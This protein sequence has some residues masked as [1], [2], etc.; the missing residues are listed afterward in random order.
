L[1]SHVTRIARIVLASDGILH[2]ADHHNRLELGERI[3]EGRVGLRQEQHVALVNR[4]PATNARAVEPE[5]I[6]EQVL[7]ELGNGDAEMLPYARKIHKAEIRALDIILPAHCQD[8][9]RRHT[10]GSFAYTL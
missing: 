9:L 1:A 3:D 2:V 7:G 10:E 8:F 5:A 4:L 6:L